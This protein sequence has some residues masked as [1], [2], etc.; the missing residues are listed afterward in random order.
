MHA[1][2]LRKAGA[3]FNQYLKKNDKI[4]DVGS[5][6]VQQASQN[7]VS[8]K[9]LLPVGFAEYTGLDI[10]PGNNVDLV[11]KDP[12]K[13]TEIEDNTFDIV[14]SGSVFEHVEFFWLVFEEMTR[15]LKP[16][17]YML[18]IV[19]KI[20]MQHK[21]PVDCWRFYPDCMI[22]LAK[23][24]GIKCIRADAEYIPDYTKLEHRP[25]DCEGVFQK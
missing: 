5:A 23:Y 15:V 1:S 9:S 25:Y 4:L 2:S 24:T 8:Y 10:E 22:A 16:G 21:Y 13:W 17:G 3:F 20:H 12:Y 14:M 18:L 19:P 11:V 7:A 6:I